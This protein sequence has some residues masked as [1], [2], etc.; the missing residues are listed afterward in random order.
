MSNPQSLRKMKRVISKLFHHK[1]IHSKDDLSIDIIGSIPEKL[2]RKVDYKKIQRKL[3]ANSVD[4]ISYEF[5][6]TSKVKTL[7]LLTL[8]M[9]LLL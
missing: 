1:F 4:V 6:W 7:L 5:F 9:V 8:K 3:K 2:K